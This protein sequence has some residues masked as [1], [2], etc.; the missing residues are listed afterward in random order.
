MAEEATTVQ[1][2]AVELPVTEAEAAPVEAEIPALVT[3]LSTE[4]KPSVENATKAARSTGK[5]QR[6][7]R[8]TGT[9]SR[10]ELPGEGSR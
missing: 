8:K 5:T 10:T 2:T 7:K 4:A 1:Q 3:E 9:P 6:N